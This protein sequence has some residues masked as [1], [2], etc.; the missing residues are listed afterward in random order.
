MGDAAKGAKLF[1]SRAE[2]CHTVNKGGQHKTGPNLFG[3][4]GK[5]IAS[6]ADFTYSNAFKAADVV[7]DEETL[8]KYLENPKKYIPGTKMN[9]AG[10]KKESDRLDIIAYLK[11]LA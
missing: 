7:W 9:F 4:M 10:L 5:K 6:T 2:Q 1:K 11:G 8:N 3:I